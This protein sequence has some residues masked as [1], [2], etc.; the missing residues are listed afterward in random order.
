VYGALL[1][2]GWSA[3]DAEAALDV[4][5]AEAGDD[6]PVPELLRLT[7]RTLGRVT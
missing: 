7:L 4:A 2:L 1:N 3:R 5:T 6:L